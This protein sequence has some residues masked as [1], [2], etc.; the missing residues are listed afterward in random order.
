MD[1]QKIKELQKILNT[2]I[3][4]INNRII[5]R[6]RKINFKEILYGSI[7]KCINNSSYQD[8]SSKINLNFIENNINTTISKT[9]F[10]NKKNSI[11]SDYFLNINDSIVEYIFKNDKTPRIYAVDGSFINLFKNFNK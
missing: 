4:N 3:K 6:N 11:S 2:N 10:I 8:V 5:L 7:Y 1:I 9:A